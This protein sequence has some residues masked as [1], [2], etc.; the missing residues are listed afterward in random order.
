MSTTRPPLG[1]LGIV[2][3]CTSGAALVG[4][5]VTR[6]FVVPSFV[7]M[8]QD[9]GGELPW[10][11]QAAIEPGVSATLAGLSLALC[12]TG[13]WRR[14]VSLLVVST[15]LAALAIVFTVVALYAPI[16]ELAGAVSAE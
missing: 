16:F 10:I 2:F 9:F 5:A 7:S 1:T 3:A 13:L 15:V 12:G 4:L 11:T 8:F 6:F 14:R